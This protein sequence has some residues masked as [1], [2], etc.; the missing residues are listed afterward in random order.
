MGANIQYPYH[1]LPM[2]SIDDRIGFWALIGIYE[3]LMVEMNGT[4]DDSKNKIEI[5]CEGRRNDEM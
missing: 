2:F 5:N 1:D 4:E 3:D